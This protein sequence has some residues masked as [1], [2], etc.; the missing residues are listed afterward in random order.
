MR[1]KIKFKADS[2]KIDNNLSS[3]NSYIHKCLGN[4]NKYHDTTSN[5]NISQ[6]LNTKVVD[7]GKSLLCDDPYI[8]LSS[9]DLDFINTFMSNCHKYD[10]NEDIKFDSIEFV[11]VDLFGGYNFFKTIGTGVLLKSEGELI[12]AEKA[13][14]IDKL[15]ESIQRKY[16]LVF[17][18]EYDKDFNIE[19]SKFLTRNIIVKTNKSVVSD[20]VFKVSG[21]KDISEFIYYNGIGKSTGSGFGTISIN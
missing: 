10:Y 14:F 3:L 9:L 4:N 2:V 11:K 16:K 12:T 19:I 6:L 17:E 8:L 7:G 15:K 13:N 18:K 20:I 1:V 21:D 5:Y